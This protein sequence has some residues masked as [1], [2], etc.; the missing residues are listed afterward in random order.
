MKIILVPGNHN[1]RV[2]QI[3]FPYLINKLKEKNLQVIAKNMPDPM[4]ARKKIWLPFMESELKADENTIGV[5]HSSG[6]IAWL[7]Y[8]ETH[9]LK[10]LILV[11]AYYT[12]LG[13]ATEKASG[14]F[15]APWNWEQINSNVDFIVQFASIDDP[16]IPV[17]ES[18]F[19]K[20]KLPKLEY[21]EFSD[22]GHMGEDVNLVEFP[23]L[24]DA[25]LTKITKSK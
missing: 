14:Y 1:S 9:K 7:R 12:D 10:G 11:G 25:I 16:Y 20:T 13:D 4:V 19:L 8:A 5:G 17:A 18:R 22:K 2:D 24:L 6:A 15:D 21:I 3:W 23:E